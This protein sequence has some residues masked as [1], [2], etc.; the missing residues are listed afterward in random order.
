[1]GLSRNPNGPLIHADLVQFREVV[2]FDRTRPPSI[3]E[4]ADDVEY[5]VKEPDRLD[6]IAWQTLGN[7][8]LGWVIAERNNLRLFPNDLVPGRTLF[9]PSI[10][11]LKERG[12]IP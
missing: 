2:W 3:G 5:L 4:R 11:G 6:T 1:M 10:T 9:I 12:I 7:P 8:Y